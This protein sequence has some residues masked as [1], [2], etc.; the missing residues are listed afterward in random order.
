MTEMKFGQLSLLSDRAYSCCNTLIELRLGAQL[1]GKQSKNTPPPPLA[2]MG[3][4]A[5][6][7][8]CQRL[9]KN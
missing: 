2:R 3:F 9:E 1:A 5:A 8:V 7:A 6:S 4:S